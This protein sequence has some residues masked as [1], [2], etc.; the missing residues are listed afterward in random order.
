[1]S[2]SKSALIAACV[3]ATMSVG[4][5]DAGNDQGA[6]A[7]D[8]SKDTQAARVLE[9]M[10]YPERFE[11]AIGETAKVLDVYRMKKERTLKD[12]KEIESVRKEYKTVTDQLAWTVHKQKYIDV[13]TIDFSAK[14]LE[15][16]ERFY[17]SPVGIRLVNLKDKD[18][19][20]VYNAM[21][22]SDSL[23][24]LKAAHTLSDGDLKL[25]ITFFSKPLGK[26]FLGTIDQLIVV[27]Q[28]TEGFVMQLVMKQ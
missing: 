9:G 27:D 5:N 26:K 20:L 4:A 18:R 2:Y 28:Q 23:K 24:K 12:P 25:V 3:A 10:K 7:V 14:Q 1:M 21:R 22:N 15:E 6:K 16:V 17:R 11:K 19:D 13:L 8:N